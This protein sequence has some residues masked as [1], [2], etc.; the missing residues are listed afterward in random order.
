M[1]SSAGGFLRPDIRRSRALSSLT[2][3]RC[4]SFANTISASA[5]LDTIVSHVLS[6]QRPALSK[7]HLQHPRAQPHLRQSNTLNLDIHPLRQLLHGN[8][9]PRW[10]A[11]EML[12]I[13]SVHTRE[14]GHIR[15]EHVDLDDSLHG[16]ASFREDGLDI[17]ATGCS[18]IRDAG[19][20]R[21][22]FAGC[23]CGDLTGHVDE[24]WGL[25][26]LGL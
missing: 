4:Q 9:T 15:Q 24:C 14:V 10:L 19:T 18:L 21:K 12:L 1:W 2:L 13:L 16:R 5:P 11:D 26:G 17:G 25:D 3:C 23:I 20:L 7:P 22:D 8:T 6:R